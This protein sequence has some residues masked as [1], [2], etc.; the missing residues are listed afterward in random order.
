M[1]VPIRKRPW[2][3]LWLALWATRVAAE[4]LPRFDF[5]QL[6]GLGWEAAHDLELA[7]TM[8]GM[9]IT[10]TGSDPFTNGPPRDF[11]EGQ[12]L[13][14]HLRARCEKGGSA[15]IFYFR[16]MP[17]EQDS[18]LFTM[19]DDE[20]EDF[21]VPLPALGPAHRVRFDPPGKSGTC[22]LISMSF[23]PRAKPESSLQLPPPKP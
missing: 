16:E 19:R 3:T 15:Q 9:R 4:S 22:L 10:I 8:D 7:N 11:P 13:T 2:W 12:R 23:S 21:K 20:L 1:K 18:V 14:L 5:T 6:G 17:S